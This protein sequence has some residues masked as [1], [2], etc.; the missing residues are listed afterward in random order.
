MANHH[1]PTF[2]NLALIR[3]PA[4]AIV[5]ALHRISGVI[6]SLLV[7]VLVYLLDLSLQDSEGFAQVIGFFNSLGVKL[8]GMVV[9]WALLHHIFAGIRFLLFDIH[10]GVKDYR[11]SWSARIANV[12]ALVV[13]LLIAGVLW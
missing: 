1:R 13:T 8:V 10:V 6:L 11:P 5:S 12:S 2:L 9:L 7:P 4:N 3:F